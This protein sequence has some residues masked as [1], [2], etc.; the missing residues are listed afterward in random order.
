[1][2]GPARRGVPVSDPLISL[3]A[4]RRRFP[5]A[6]VD[7]LAGVDLTVATGE[8]LAVVG[9]SGSGKSTLLFV[10][11]LLDTPTSGSVALG[12]RDVGTLDDAA[13][14]ALRREHLGFVFQDH[15]L[16]PQATA[17]ENVLVP[18]FADGRPNA[19][20]R[21][22]ARDLL[23]RLGLGDRLDHRPEAL[24]TGQRQRVA[25][26]RAL[27][28]RPRLVLADEPTGSLDRARARELVDLLTRLQDDVAVVVV[29][30]DPEVAAAFPRTLRLVD[31]RLADAAVAG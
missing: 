21:D 28:R 3:T 10:M 19:A 18:W 16:L 24:S 9:P 12:G 14:A 7:T 26:A 8:R 1:M 2:P 5:G 20:A 23:T 29:T 15:H 17:L 25:V 22:R 31:G 13:R 30:H 11:G 4:V 27:V 6:E